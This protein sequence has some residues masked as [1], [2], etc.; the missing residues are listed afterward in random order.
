VT[1]LEV[2]GLVA[3][4]RQECVGVY[5]DDFLDHEAEKIIANAVESYEKRIRVLRL[6]LRNF[7]EINASTP[8]VKW[9]ALNDLAAV[10]RTVLREEKS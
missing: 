5:G 2:K 10:V 7:I 6:L 8:E 3:H 9:I 1:S 4:I